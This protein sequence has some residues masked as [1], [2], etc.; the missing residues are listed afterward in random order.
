VNLLAGAPG[1]TFPRSRA[2]GYPRSGEAH[3]RFSPQHSVTSLLSFI[4][5][6][7]RCY[8]THGSAAARGEYNR[9]EP[10]L[11]VRGG[12]APACLRI[13]RSWRLLA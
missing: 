3:R 6:E 7:Q 12:S 8:L 11:A 1:A 9:F 5:R 2:G 13:L 4:V 10:W